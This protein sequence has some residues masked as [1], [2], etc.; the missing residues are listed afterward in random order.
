M[1]ASNPP[2]ITLE[3]TGG[4]LTI[5]TAEAIYRIMVTGGGGGQTAA[6]P[7]EPA[8]PALPQSPPPAPEPV[9]S[10]DDDWDDLDLPAPPEQPP[11]VEKAE[12]AP[13][14]EEYYRELSHEMY[15]EVGRLARRLSMSIRDVKVDKVDGIDLES[16]GQQ[17]EQAKDQLESVVKMTEQATMKI[18][19]LGEDIQNAINKARGI[20][21]Q[22]TT[23]EAA[24][25][26]EG[27]GSAAAQVQEEL[28][29]ALAQLKEY[30]DKLGQEPLAPLVEKAQALREELAQAGGGEAPAPEPEPE[31]EPEPSGPYYQFSLDL[32][33]QTTYEMCTNETVK[34]HV[35]AMWDVAAKT[36]DQK[37]IE[38]ELNK[39]VTDPP[40]EDNFLNLDLKGVLKAL[41]QATKEDRFKQVLKKMAGTV[42][43]IFLEPSLPLEAVPGKP[44]APEKKAAP[45]PPPAPAGP[46]P[47][48]LAKLEELVSQLQEKAQELTPP[49]LPDLE[50]LLQKLVESVTPQA[51]GGVS[52]ELV[53]QL[54]EVMSV[55]FTSV[56]S[57]IEALSFQDLSGQ[58]IYRIVKL[59]TD[60]QVQLLAMLV[61]FGTKLK[62]KEEKKE[63]DVE[64]SEKMAQEEV[65]KALASIGLAEDEGEAEP[66]KLDQDSI[67]SLLESMGF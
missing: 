51:G 56:N 13:D 55:I 59:L 64:E 45:A 52:P 44:P 32:V 65:D 66:S 27:D 48:T 34:K 41:F 67:N 15:R 16:A 60:F 47:E 49:P 12:G 23:S 21:E 11:E 17:L 30:L 9:P 5:R 10:P 39:L 53:E 3:L 43:Q 7:A 40:D 36:F 57:I 61:S 62:T 31:P 26:S 25:D 22:M 35:K 19:D 29:Q 33:F 20:M 14:D 2:E 24:E 50:E 8:A 46:S 42:D 6:L 18:M 4:S 37:L 38:R 63:I 54:G 28:S 58:T 1:A